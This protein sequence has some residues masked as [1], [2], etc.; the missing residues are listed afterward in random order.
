MYHFPHILLACG[1]NIAQYWDSVVVIDQMC[2]A[3]PS[4]ANLDIGGIGVSSESKS[5]LAHPLTLT[6]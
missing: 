5:L 2:G 3:G 4:N 1:A 6:H